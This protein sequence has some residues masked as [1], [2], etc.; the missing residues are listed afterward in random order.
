[1]R[2]A[3]ALAAS[4]SVVLVPDVPRWRALEVAPDQTLPTILDGLNLLEERPDVMP[5][6]VAVM[7]FS[8]GATLALLASTRPELR[9][10]LAGIAAWGGYA[11]LSREI[12]FLLTGRHEWRGERLSLEPDP[13]GRWIM[14]ANYLTAIPRYGDAADVAGALRELAE[15]AGRK[16]VYAGDSVYDPLKKELRERL[17]SGRRELFDR[18]ARLAG[19]P[20]P[21]G[22][23]ELAEELTMAVAR[24]EPELA[25]T[26]RVTGV[27]TPVVLAHGR[28]DR[29]VPFTECYRIRLMLPRDAVQHTAI[30]GMFAHSTPGTITGLLDKGAE[31]LN[32]LR[33]LRAVLNLPAG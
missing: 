31:S 4:G 28:G 26:G 24:R 19:A 32:Y 6:H 10:R 13:Y 29:L 7:G 9:D 16:R 1:M 3:R 17:P 8:F 15:A 33:M 22:M 23:D 12:E 30:T 11:D 2:F 27:R 25:W 14:G 21:E 20:Q 5:G 18:F